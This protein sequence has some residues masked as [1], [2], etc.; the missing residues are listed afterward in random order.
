MQLRDVAVPPGAVTLTLP[1]FHVHQEVGN[2]RCM[3]IR[4]ARQ[5]CAQE[6]V[7]GQFKV[8]AV[9]LGQ[10]VGQ[11]EAARRLGVPVAT[12]GNW[13]RRGK[14]ALPQL[15]GKTVTPAAGVPARRPVGELEAEN[16]RLRGSWRSPNWTWRYFEK[17]RRTSQRDRD[18]VCLDREQRDD[19][20]VSR[21][22]RVLGVSRT[23]YCQWRVRQPSAR[24]RADEALDTQVAAIHRQ[25]RASYGRPRITEQLHQQG[26]RVGSERVRRSL[27]RQGLRPA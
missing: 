24:T 8:E 5:Q 23:G 19:Y 4:N 21:L 16:S 6:A 2:Y 22:C 20:T 14:T 17:R 25:N 3:E 10:S 1:R 18:E 26:H 13:Y 9:R 7:H 11:H 27:K 12:L 15:Q